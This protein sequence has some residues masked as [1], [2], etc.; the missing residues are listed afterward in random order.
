MGGQCP[1]TRCQMFDERRV[2]RFNQLLQERLL[3]PVLG[4][5]ARTRSPSVL[6]DH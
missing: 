5:L 2:V 4:M 3:G 6:A 1:L